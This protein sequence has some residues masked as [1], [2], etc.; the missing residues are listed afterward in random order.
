MSSSPHSSA[1]VAADEVPSCCT[2]LP[3]KTQPR[4]HEGV[5][6]QPSTWG[7]VSTGVSGVADMATKHS[8]VACTPH[9][10]ALIRKDALHG[11]NVA[12]CCKPE[13]VLHEFQRLFDDDYPTVNV[14]APHGF[15]VLAFTG[16]R[17]SG[18]RPVWSNLRRICAASGCPG[19][20]EGR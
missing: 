16:S 5:R 11:C 3:T 2:S 20:S 17:H 12:S 13:S 9:H 4:Q 18:H 7:S 8:T 14:E 10:A 19:R 1:C 15:G 6:N